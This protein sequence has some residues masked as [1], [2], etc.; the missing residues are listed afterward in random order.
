MMGRVSA[1][2]QLRAGAAVFRRFGT[3]PVTLAPAVAAAVADLLDA[4]AAEAERLNRLAL[5]F[6]DPPDHY[7][8]KLAVAVA[9]AVLWQEE[10]TP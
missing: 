3:Q 10:P 9:R 6:G 4:Q 5:N 2:E 7:A 8:P 1:A